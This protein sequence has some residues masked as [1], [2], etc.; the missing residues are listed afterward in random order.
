[1]GMNELFD[2]FVRFAATLP[3]A[4]NYQLRLDP[5]GSG[6]ITTED[7]GPRDIL[8]WNSLPEG[9]QKLQEALKGQEQTPA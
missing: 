6:S 5:E 1:M 4:W 3:D 7:D 9:I 2:L 8:Y